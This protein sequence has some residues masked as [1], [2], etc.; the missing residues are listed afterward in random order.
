MAHFSEYLTK[1]TSSFVFNKLLL[2]LLRFD[3]CCNGEYGA[4]V[5]GVLVV[6]L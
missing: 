3:D 1:D 5:M 4:I 2:I 6:I